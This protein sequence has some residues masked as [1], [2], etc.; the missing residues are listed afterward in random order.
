[1]SDKRVPDHNHRP[2]GSKSKD[3]R[4]RPNPE[5]AA[6]SEY[7]SPGIRFLHLFG[8]TSLA[9]AQPVLGRLS[10]NDSY[11]E[12]DRI[13]GFALWVGLLTLAL[14]L[15]GLLLTVNRISDAINPRFGR[16]VFT[17]QIF[18]LVT[19]FAQQWLKWIAGHRAMMTLA[20]PD[21]L[22]AMTSLAA[23]Y[24]AV[25]LYNR[26]RGMRQFLTVLS[27]C[28]VAVPVAFVM[29]P[30]M[31]SMLF[32]RGQQHDEVPG[33]QAQN[34]VPVVMI[35][36]DGLNGMALLNEQLEID[37]QRYPAFAR[38]AAMSTWYRNAST[39]HYRTDNA[40]PA[41]L[42]GRV[43]PGNLVPFEA[44]YPDNLFRRIVDSR[45]YEVTVFE[46]YTRLCPRTIRQTLQRRGRLD[47]LQS[48]LGTL[49]RVYVKTTLPDEISGGHRMIPRAWFGFQDNQ[50]FDETARTGLIAYGWD[51]ERGEQLEHFRN[52]L[53]RSDKPWFRFL[54]VVLPHYPWNYLPS[55]RQHMNLLNAEHYP[56][57]AH[58]TL[59]EDWGPDELAVNHAWQRYV[60]QLGFVDH[61]LGRILDQME[62]QQILDESLLVVVA[63]HGV[64]F[65]A[66]TSRREPTPETLTDI[67]PVPLFV[68]LPS[69][70]SGIVSDRNVENIDVFPTVAELLQ[71]TPEVV[72]DGVSLLDESARE[73]PRKQM[74]GP[75]GPFIVEPDFPQRFDYVRR[76]TALFDSGA[77]EKLWL[78]L[79][80]IP[81]LVGADVNDLLDSGDGVAVELFFAVD[82]SA[83]T[84]A[85]FV[86][87]FIR[88]R[89][90]SLSGGKA[91]PVELAITVNGRIG[92]T[93]RTYT[94][95]L[96][97]TEW[98][99]MLPE[100]RFEFGPNDIAVFE[101]IRKA[102]Q[103]RLKRCV[104]LK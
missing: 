43:P 53:I 61:F 63:D 8:L 89:I 69:Q 16:A 73:R 57:G 65:K 71:L 98:A 88:G 75:D 13:E 83:E 64:A 76:A 62:E 81:E 100:S 23:A 72:T 101:V 3:P 14:G 27:C 52:C 82:T 9:I 22:W 49:T 50:S 28:A 84:T 93:T 51:T 42:T 32:M 12:I 20:V 94:D 15:P 33:Y 18:F 60:L 99:A 87:C 77:S 74:A 35:V 41:I 85:E 70:H 103:F 95:P 58:G 68:K 11:L 31:N 96:I 86:P 1:M 34:P 97:T 55:G 48:L 26:R 46:P 5:L 17:G 7:V 90:P 91:L 66:G 56:V 24:F 2:D 104:L 19:L 54:H 40:V 39:V 44:N 45:Q 25:T 80:W 36:L 21:V 78:G 59:G 30:P 92:A 10:T 6:T 37:A 4:P 47:Q 102:N 29:A 79:N 38:L 67:M